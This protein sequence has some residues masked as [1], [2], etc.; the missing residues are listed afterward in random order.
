MDIEILF[1]Y[2]NCFLCL[3]KQGADPNLYEGNGEPPLIWAARSNRDNEVKI[4]LEA[5]ANPNVKSAGGIT[6]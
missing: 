6:Q 5:G 4:L 3:L 1:F 2:F